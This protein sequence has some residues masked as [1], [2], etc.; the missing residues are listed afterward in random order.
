RVMGAT[1]S[2]KST[3]VNLLSGSTLHVGK[4]LRSCTSDVEATAPFDFQ[5]RR[6][7]MFDTPGFDDTTKSDTDILKLVATYLATTYEHGAKLAGVIY[8][9]RINDIRMGGIAVRNFGMF[10][11]LCGD[12][13]LKNVAI[14]TNFWSEVDPAVGDAREAELRGDDTFFKPVLEKQAK[15]LRHDGTL[16]AAHAVIAQIVD[17]QPMALLIQEELVDEHKSISDTAAGVEV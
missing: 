11:K 3:F 5:G 10:R 16:A 9:H 8:M 14:V 15:L 2:G 7:V 6:L 17:N 12:K 4:G 13:S 1:G